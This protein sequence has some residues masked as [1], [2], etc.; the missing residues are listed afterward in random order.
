MKR[1][2]I[3]NLDS[4]SIAVDSIEILPDGSLRVVNRAKEIGV[5]GGDGAITFPPETSVG[6]VYNEE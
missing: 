3:I 2:L 6:I 5:V 1:T 4:G